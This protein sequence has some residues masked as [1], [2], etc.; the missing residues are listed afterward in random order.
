M[1]RLLNRQDKDEVEDTL[2]L[3]FAGDLGADITV[4]IGKCIGDSQ[5]TT[6]QS[7][8]SYKELEVS[9]LDEVAT[10]LQQGQDEVQKLLLRLGNGVAS[11]LERV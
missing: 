9:N 11:R 4:K 2:G 10:K 5:R 1:A 7:L 8:Q 6:L 3:M